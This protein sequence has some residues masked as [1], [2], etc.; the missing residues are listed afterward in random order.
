MKLWLIAQESNHGHDTYDSA[1]VAA[2]TEE[3]A[4]MFHPGEY[5]DWNGKD[6][7]TWVNAEKVSVRLIGEAVTGT[8]PGVIIASFNAG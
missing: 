7:G 6:D 3:E 8:S 1:V 5:A 2:E 4:A